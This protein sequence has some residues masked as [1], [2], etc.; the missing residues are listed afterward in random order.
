MLDGPGEPVGA[1][2]ADQRLRLHQGP[3]ALLEEERIALRPL[4]QEPLERAERRV[5]AEQRLEQLVGALGRQRIEPELAVV[6]L[7]APGVLVLGAVVDEEQEARRGQALDEAVEQRLG[8]GVDPVQVLEDQQQRLDLALAQQ[9]ALDRVERALPALG[10]VERLPRR[11]RRRARR[12]APGAPAASARAPRS[13][14]R[15]L[16]VT[17]SRISRGVVA[18]SI[19]K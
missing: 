15:S 17:F 11:H 8:L 16:P 5:G 18:V 1:A 4:D 2:L 13:S 6:G 12:A 10:R 7:A 14:V 19:S 9:Q 3:H